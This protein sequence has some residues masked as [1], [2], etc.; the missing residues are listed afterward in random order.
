MTPATTTILLYLLAL[1]LAVAT[2]WA[3]SEVNP[4][5]TDPALCWLIIIA[6][7]PFVMLVFFGL[8][9]LISD[10]ISVG[11]P[12]LTADDNE[13]TFSEGLVLAVSYVGLSGWLWWRRRKWTALSTRILGPAIVATLTAFIII[14]VVWAEHY[15]QYFNGSTVQRTQTR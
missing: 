11:A 4:K 15:D 8:A 13:L 10:T 7:I 9:I 6:V 2:L 5:E 14:S 1:F 3:F 12:W